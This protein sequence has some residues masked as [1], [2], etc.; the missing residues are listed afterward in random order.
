AA[1]GREQ[2]ADHAQRG[3]LARA[4]GPQEAA[5]AALLDGEGDAVDDRARA[6]ALHPIMDVYREG[7]EPTSAKGA[8]LTGR[9]GA[10]AMLSG[11]LSGRASIR[12][13]SLLLALCE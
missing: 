12:N 5:D 11:T 8:T 4:V 3:G 10:S 6:I 13:T 2:A 1:V 7:H 9:P